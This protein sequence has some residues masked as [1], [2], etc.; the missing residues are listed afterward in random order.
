MPDPD[1]FLAL[2]TPVDPNTPD[3]GLPGGGWQSPGR[4]DHDL[5]PET[6]P[7]AGLWP[8]LPTDLPTQLP[9]IGWKPGTIWPPLVD[10]TLPTPPPEVGGGPVEPPPV[11][12]GGPAEPPPVV[13]G[14]PVEPPP[15]VGGGPVTPPTPSPSKVVVLLAWVPG[16]GFRW[17]VVDL[18][19][20]PDNS[21][22]APPPTVTPPIATP[23]PV[24]TP[25]IATPPDSP[26]TATPAV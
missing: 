4:P 25:P 24:A 6:D 1:P 19:L 17:V 7:P 26:P 10:N 13:G 16:H 2:I 3:Q 15:T 14:G 22:P 18:S 11:V 23:P 20:T 21:L 8:P 5:P 9:S 12:G